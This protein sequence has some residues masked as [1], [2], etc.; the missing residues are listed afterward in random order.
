MTPVQPHPLRLPDLPDRFTTA[1]LLVRCP[2]PGDGDELFQA[3]V[4]TLPTAPVARVV[5]L[6]PIRA[7]GRCLGVVLPRR[8]RGVPRAA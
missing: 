8:A 6:G 1:H 5:A 4:E 3:V 2:R 7:I